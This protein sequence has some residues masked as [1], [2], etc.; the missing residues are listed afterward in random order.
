MKLQLLAQQ[1][2]STMTHAEAVNL[3]KGQVIKHK[4]LKNSNG[5]PQRFKINGK[6]TLFKKGG[7]RIPL[8]RGLGLYYGY[9]TKE[10][11]SDFHPPD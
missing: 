1:D 10:N 11:V 2:F 9:L 3:K 5:S 6:V 7:Y 8:K 4:H